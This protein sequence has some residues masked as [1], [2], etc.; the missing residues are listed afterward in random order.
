MHNSPIKKKCILIKF[1]ICRLIF[2]FPF[3]YSCIIIIIII[4]II[5]LLFFFLMST[6]FF[7]FTY[8][9]HGGVALALGLVGLSPWPSMDVLCTGWTLMKRMITTQKMPW[10]QSCCHRSIVYIFSFVILF[11][12]SLSLLFSLLF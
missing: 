7:F 8:C 11:P 5:Y 12:P 4:I 2:F 6:H 1:F 9:P 10:S 3:M